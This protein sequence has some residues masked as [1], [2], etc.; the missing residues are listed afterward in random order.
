MYRMRFK[1]MQRTDAPVTKKDYCAGTEAK[2]YGITDE[3]CKYHISLIFRHGEILFQS[4]VG[5][6]TI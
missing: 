5:A 4:P 3:K 1:L 6:A 2:I